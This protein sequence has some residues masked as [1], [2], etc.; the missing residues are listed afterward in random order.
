MTPE[1]IKRAIDVKKVVKAVKKIGLFALYRS[2]EDLT[3]LMTQKFTLNLNKE[4]AWEVQCALLVQ[5]IGYWHTAVSRGEPIKGNAVEQA[6]IDKYFRLAK[7]DAEIIQFSGIHM[8]A[9]SIYLGHHEYVAIKADYLQ[10]LRSPMLRNDRESGIVIAADCHL[11]APED[12]LMSK[13]LMNPMFVDR[14]AK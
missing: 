10:M 6:E 14:E 7:K 13:F 11:I 8:G 4:Q 9:N 2:S 5:D 3:L 12:F 1:D